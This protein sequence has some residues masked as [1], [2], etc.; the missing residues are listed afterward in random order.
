MKKIF[1]SEF[2]PKC[3]KYNL[4][5]EHSDFH[6]IEQCENDDCGYKYE[7]YSDEYEEYLY[8]NSI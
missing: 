4:H 5:I 6:H 2:C 8:K 7:E 3:R 1:D